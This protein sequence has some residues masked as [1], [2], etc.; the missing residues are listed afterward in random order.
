M[1]TTIDAKRVTKSQRD[2]MGAFL[3]ST[4]ALQLLNLL[5]LVFLSISYLNIANKK[6]PSLVQLSNGQSFTTA[7]MGNKERTPAVIQRFTA[8]TLTRLMTWTGKLPAASG[9]NQNYQPDVG[10][11]IKTDKGNK[12]IATTTWQASFAVSEDFR[13]ELLRKLAELTPSEVFSGQSQVVLVTQEVTPPIQVAP[14]KWKVSVV[15]NLQ[16]FS[17]E[18][19]EGKAVPF[20]K[21][22][23]IQAVDT[24]PLASGS[25]PL[26]QVIYEI[27]QARLEIYAMRDLPQQNLTQ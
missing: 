18:Q 9:V 27:R 24:A 4:S 5:F 6:P 20:N 26:E 10:V 17:K 12:R 13:P 7:P 1:K 23:F 2:V 21:E 14:G 22:V 15:A 25:T 16:V 11:E 19:S 3:V 8:D